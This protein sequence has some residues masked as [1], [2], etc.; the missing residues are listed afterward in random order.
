[1]KILAPLFLFPQNP[2][3]VYKFM[4]DQSTK[5]SIME[6]KPLHPLHQIAETPTHKLLLKQWLKEEELIL[7][8]TILK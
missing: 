4:D 5:P 7:G 8:R 3:S 6:S 1:L 2:L